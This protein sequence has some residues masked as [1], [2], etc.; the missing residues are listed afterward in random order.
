VDPK[1][2]LFAVPGFVLA[3]GG[4]LWLARRRGLRLHRRGDTLSNLATGIGAELL[5]PLFA[6]LTVGIYAWIQSR[7]ALAHP[8]PRSLAAWVVLFFAVDLCYYWFHRASHRINFLWA[9]H[10]VHHQSEEYNLSTALRQSWIGP[11]FGWVFYLPLALAGFPAGMFAVMLTANLIY[12]FWI[13]TRLIDRLGPLELV[14]NTPSHHRVHHGT[15]PR[16]I[17]RNYAGVLI[18]WDRLFGTFE[19]ERET[20]R[21]G[22][23]VPL[24]SFDPLWA[25]LHRW[26]E[27]ARMARA[28][29]RLADRLRV[30]IAPPEWKPDAKIVSCA[31]S[32]LPPASPAAECPVP[33]ITS[34]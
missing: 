23:V 5:A 19:P 30:W 33:P 16:Y 17:D 22:L 25:N 14:L 3:L 8:S 11:L 12:Q 18:V 29:R 28:A 21:Y 32:P 15:N 1:L 7:F 6:P 31:P 10:A 24:G 34:S 27:L 13:H 9:L 4:E 26:V 20:V 2:I